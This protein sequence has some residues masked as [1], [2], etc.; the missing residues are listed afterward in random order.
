MLGFKR[1]LSITLLSTLALFGCEQKANKDNTVSVQSEE[2]EITQAMEDAEKDARA[3]VGMAE[4]KQLL[5]SCLDTA[6]QSYNSNQ[7]CLNF[8]NFR[9]GNKLGDV[10]KENNLVIANFEVSRD[11]TV[12]SNALCIASGDIIPNTKRAYEIPA[13]CGQFFNL[14]STDLVNWTPIQLVGIKGIEQTDLGGYALEQN[15]KNELSR[16]IYTKHNKRIGCF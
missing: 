1:A 11:C 5:D 13:S 12:N 16:L 8:V 4:A 7:S 2:L 9:N 3:F 6:F 14:Y 15:D 10:L